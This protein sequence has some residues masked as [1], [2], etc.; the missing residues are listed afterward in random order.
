MC[1]RDRPY[2]ASDVVN[3]PEEPIVLIAHRDRAKAD[4][5]RRRVTIDIEP[6]RPVLTID[7]ALSGRHIIWGTDNIFKSYAV[8]KG[9]VEHALAEAAI[10]VEGE[11]ETGAQEQL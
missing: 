7:E 4:D 10:V 3:H 1:I 11:Y 2:L 9:D 6:L 5:A 8:S